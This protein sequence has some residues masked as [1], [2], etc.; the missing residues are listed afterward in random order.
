[1]VDRCSR[2]GCPLQF[3]VYQKQKEMTAASGSVSRPE[4]GCGHFLFDYLFSSAVDRFRYVALELRPRSLS[5]SLS[6]GIT[7]IKAGK[8]MVRNWYECKVLPGCG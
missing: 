6:L 4:W 7:V 3:K 1:M 2:F 5:G 8:H